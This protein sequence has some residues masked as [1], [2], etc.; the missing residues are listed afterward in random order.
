M[1]PMSR[2]ADRFGA[3][4]QRRRFKQDGEVP[5]TVLPGHQDHSSDGSV[6]RLEAAETTV[7]FE[8]AAREKAQ[9]A[10]A[11]AQVT[12]RDLQTKLGHVGLAQ[13]DREMAARRHHEAIMA[14]QA[15]L[16]ETSARLTATDAEREKVQ[17]RLIAIKE[18]CAGE[19][20]A[21]LQAERA[22]R[23]A[24][25]ARTDAEQRLRELTASGSVGLSPRRPRRSPIAAK[26]ARATEPRAATRRVVPEAPEP[27]PVKWWLTSE[28]KSQRR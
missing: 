26:K 2:Q 4:S 24:E 23:D 9:R 28:K 20:S 6:N 19:R 7:A 10:L 15:E 14:V 8:R 1:T 11:E 13:S 21:R 25:A 17:Q 16:H 27:Q 3:G 5:V 22:R 12:I 18:E